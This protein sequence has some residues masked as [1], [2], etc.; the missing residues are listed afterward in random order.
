MSS[1]A[2][3]LVV[4]AKSSSYVNDFQTFNNPGSWQPVGAS[5]NSF[6]FTFLTQFFILD[7]VKLAELSHNSF[8]WKN[9]ILWGS[10]HTAT[11]PT[12]FQGVNT[13]N[14][15]DLLPLCS[16]DVVPFFT[17]VRL[18]CSWHS[19]NNQSESVT[20]LQTRIYCDL[21]K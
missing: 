18:L 2:T 10:K 1:H 21:C 5:K 8:E 11:P 12:Y 3:D 16:L 15:R 14:P 19:E 20:Y 17:A 13:P 7:D 4:Y 9:V 6:A